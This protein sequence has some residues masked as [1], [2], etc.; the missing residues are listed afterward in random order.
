MVKSIS[1]D[2]LTPVSAFLALAEGE[3]DR[4]SAGIRRR[5]GK[6]GRYTFLGAR[7]YMRVQSRGPEVVVQRG[8]KSERSSGD[9]FATLKALLREHRVAQYEGLPPFT[10]G[11]VGYFAYDIVRQLEKIGEHATDDLNVPDCVLMFFDRLLA[12]DHLR[13]QIHIVA[14][15]DLTRE[16]PRPA[17]DRAVADINRIEKKLARGWSPRFGRNPR[18]P[19]HR[20]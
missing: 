20:N 15:A 1:A 4:I 11:A 14:T 18:R 2:L 8:R 7:P 13:H 6:I 10:G 19:G 12:F 5:W 17:Y 3:P 16:K 9:V